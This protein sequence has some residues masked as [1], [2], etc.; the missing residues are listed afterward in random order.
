MRRPFTGP[1]YTEPC[2]ECPECDEG[3]L[4][5]E[6][7]TGSLT[8]SVCGYMF[9]FLKGRQHDWNGTDC[10]TCHKPA[11]RCNRS[12]GGLYGYGCGRIK[13]HLGRHR[14]ETSVTRTNGRITGQSVT[15]WGVADEADEERWD[16]T[17]YGGDF[18][19]DVP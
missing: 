4:E 16:Q 11:P 3:F 1:A 8:C 2:P 5:D 7:L 12:S 9:R 13:G 10:T 14:A 19:E 6:H 15:A 18:W 17:R